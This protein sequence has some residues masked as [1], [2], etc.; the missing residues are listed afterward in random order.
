ECFV[1]LE[2]DQFQISSQQE[3]VFQFAG[4]SPGDNAEASQFGATVSGA[5]FGDIAG[6]RGCSAANLRRQ[7]KSFFA[8]E[9]GGDW[10]ER[11]GQV[12]GLLPH[13]QVSKVPSWTGLCLISPR[14]SRTY[15]RPLGAEDGVMKAFIDKYED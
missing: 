15:S 1:V 3:L 5:A 4:R 7:A 12:V 2:L 14:Q 6:N 10:V 9:R 11:P 13:L 8:W